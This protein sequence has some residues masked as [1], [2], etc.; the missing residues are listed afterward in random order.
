[1][2]RDGDITTEEAG[3]NYALARRKYWASPSTDEGALRGFEDAGDLLMAAF[4]ESTGNL[5][6]PAKAYKA[7]HLAHVRSVT[8][9]KK[10][11]VAKTVGRT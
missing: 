2:C 4:A 1:M 9:S 11:P 7:Y 8:T 6:Q 10:N 3:Q 5:A